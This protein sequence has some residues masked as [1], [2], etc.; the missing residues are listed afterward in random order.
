MPKM[1]TKKAALKRYKVTANG[2]V[3]ISKR[4][5]R[6]LQTKK[7]ASRRNNLSKAGILKKSETKRAKRL[8][9]YS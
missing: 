9:P 5:K 2:K 8:L 1:K 7:S 4:G 6:H 3:K